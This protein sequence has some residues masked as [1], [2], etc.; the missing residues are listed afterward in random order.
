VD[1]IDTADIGAADEHADH[2][3]RRSDRETPT[4]KMKIDF[5]GRPRPSW[6]TSCSLFCMAWKMGVSASRSRDIVALER[7]PW[8][9]K[10]AL[11]GGARRWKWALSPVISAPAPLMPFAPHARTRW[12][13]QEGGRKIEIK[14]G[15]HSGPRLVI[16]AFLWA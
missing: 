3:S 14:S 13:W 11:G 15:S 2:V 16:T 7:F 12:R 1:I 5:L 6:R 10:A 8:S 4:P 9:A